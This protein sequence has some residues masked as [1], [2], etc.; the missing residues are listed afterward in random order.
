MWSVTVLLPADPVRS[1]TARFPGVVAPGCE[2]VVP[3]G[4]TVD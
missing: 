2:W 3:E 1:L 4:P